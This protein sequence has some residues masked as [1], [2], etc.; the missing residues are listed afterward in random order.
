MTKHESR[1]PSPNIT[2]PSVPEAN[3]RKNQR[4]GPG[5]PAHSKGEVHARQDVHVR[6]QPYEE[7]LNEMR[8]CPVFDGDGS[9]TYRLA[10][11]RAGFAISRRIF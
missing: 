9:N 8:F 2:G 3:L 5:M 1:T 7:Y 11:K 4:V 10:G 6:R